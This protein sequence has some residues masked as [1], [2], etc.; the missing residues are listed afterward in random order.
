MHYFE[1]SEDKQENKKRKN[2]DKENN[3][4]LKK[5]KSSKNDASNVLR[6]IMRNEI[7]ESFK[8]EISSRALNLPQIISKNPTNI[9]NNRESKLQTM[10]RL[11]NL[12]KNV[13]K[14]V[15]DS[16]NLI[17]QI[18]EC[19]SILSDIQNNEMGILLDHNYTNSSFKQNG[20]K[21]LKGIDYDRFSLLKNANDLLPADKQMSFYIAHAELVVDSYYADCDSD[22]EGMDGESYDEDYSGHSESEW[23]ESDQNSKIKCWYD[24]NGNARKWASVDT[25]FFE[26]IIDPDSESKYPFISLDEEKQWK[27]ERHV[28]IQNCTRNEGCNRSTQY[29]K[30]ILSMWPKKFEFDTFLKI[31][32][33]YC[34]ELV[35]ERF[36][37]F[38]RD[39]TLKSDY[40]KLMSVIARKAQINDKSIQMMSVLLQKTN[41]L[42]F[43]KI[44]LKRFSQSFSNDQL[45][46][47]I[48]KYGWKEL[49]DSISQSLIRTNRNR[50][51]KNC[52][53]VTVN[54]FLK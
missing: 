21:D 10:I 2:E 30:F 51:T 31:D 41:C 50:L 52:D 23:E 19:L 45:T 53:L 42:N 43:C 47:L 5:Q 39:Q 4:S 17:F 12:L 29:N 18:Q 35:Y 34:V 3:V 8:E 22:D 37:N 13:Q 7:F 44:F 20:F 49:K 1:S 38:K 11:Q 6:E 27:G 24:L 9:I 36:I 48:F 32:L 25:D 14:N 54:I 28:S 33:D 15:N 16:A 40:Q 26:K 46:K